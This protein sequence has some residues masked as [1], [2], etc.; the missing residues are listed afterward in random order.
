M[1]RH[2]MTTD[3]VEAHY[4]AHPEERGGMKASAGVKIAVVLGALV[5][6][7]GIVLALGGC[8]SSPPDVAACK[9][10]MRHDYAVA[11]SDPSAPPAS[12]PPACKG[13]DDKTLVRL[14]SE[15][16]AGK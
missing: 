10:A 6:V 13:V 16:M 5:I 9:A 14:A 8:S 1:S 15:I 12:R 4:A 3:Q 7:I 11:M 2:K